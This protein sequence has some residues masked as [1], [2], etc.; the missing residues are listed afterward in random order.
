MHGRIDFLAQDLLGTGNRQF[1]DALTQ[2]LLG[3][4]DFL[5]DFRLGAGDD[6]VGLDL[7]VAL[8]FL[9]DLL[10]TLFGLGDKLG[11]LALGFA[12]GF[13]ERLAAISCSFLPRSAAARPSAIWACRSAIA[14]CSGG[15]TNFI[16]IQM[17]SPNQM[18]WPISV[19]LMF[20]LASW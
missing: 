5:V 8:G 4:F 1:G 19:A 18:A 12:Q 6:L 2:L 20:T 3:T 10:R 17:K 14:F 15:Q 11:G 16:V 7:G 9:D 13:G